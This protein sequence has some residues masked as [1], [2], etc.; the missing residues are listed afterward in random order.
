MP[1]FAR[2]LPSIRHMAKRSLIEGR[3]S[4]TAISGLEKGQNSAGQVL[5][6]WNK[7]WPTREE[8]FAVAQLLRQRQQKRQ[9]SNNYSGLDSAMF[10][11][12]TKPDDLANRRNNVVVAQN[13]AR[14]RKVKSTKVP[15]YDDSEAYRAQQEWEAQQQEQMQ[16]QMQEQQKEPEAKD[17]DHDY[18]S[19][20]EVRS[21]REA[22]FG[23]PEDNTEEDE[24]RARAD[25]E[26]LQRVALASSKQQ[27]RPLS[28]SISRK[29][30]S[31]YN[32]YRSHRTRWAEFRHSMIYGR[33]SF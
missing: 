18:E 16:E 13:A 33:T 4:L 22:V 15:N 11:P 17:G 31:P 7:D 24:D 23:Q 8:G 28:A 2:N 5:A 27:E 30:I 21:V 1:I 25:Q 32:S 29:V 12:V 19:D 10:R 3:R 26:L 14:R 9:W 20:L 6:P